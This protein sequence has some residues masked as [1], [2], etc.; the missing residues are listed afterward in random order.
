MGFVV[1]IIA[2]DHTDISGYYAGKIDHYSSEEVSVPRH[3][4]DLNLAKVY[5]HRKRAKN[6]IDKIISDSSFVTECEIEEV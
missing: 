1:K 6:A 5:K 2:R 3:T 4:D